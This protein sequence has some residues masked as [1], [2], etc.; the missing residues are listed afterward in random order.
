MRAL[1]ADWPPGRFDLVV[2]SEVL[3]VASRWLHELGGPPWATLGETMLG[4]YSRDTAPF[5][6]G[7]MTP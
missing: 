6:P 4:T 5:G 2:L 1:P 7:R 3:F